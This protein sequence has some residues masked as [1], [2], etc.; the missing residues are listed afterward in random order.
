MTRLPQIIRLGRERITY[1]VLAFLLAAGPSLAAQAAGLTPIRIAW[2]PDPNTALYVARDQ[3]IFSKMGLKPTYVEFLAAPPMFAALESKSV[4][5][6][7]MG[8]AP[9][10]IGRTQGIKIKA[11]MIAVD[12]SGSNAL[13]VQKGLKV[14]SGKDLKGLRIGAQRGTSPVYGLERFL[15]DS[16][17]NM[18][19]VKFINLTAPN[20]IPAFEKHQIDAAWVWSPWQNILVDSGGQRVSSNAKVKAFTPQVWA[21]RSEWARK[22]PE[23]LKAFVKAIG[24]G[25]QVIKVDDE[26]AVKALSTTLNVKPSMAVQMLSENDYPTLKEQ[27]SNTYQLSVVNG[28]PDGNAGLSKAIVNA[29]NFLKSVGIIN[30]TIKPAILIDTTPLRQAVAE[31]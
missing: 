8:T 25:M 6:A 24:A 18:S 17:L 7:D 16:G 26:A 10:I 28:Y 11:V 5:I 4:D 14:T 1:F 20:V 15:K 22:H 12:V 2:Q 29:E 31:K 9:F 23:A 21:V 30:T 13:I 3:G 27:V 19:D